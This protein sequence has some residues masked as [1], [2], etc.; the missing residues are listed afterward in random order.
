MLKS[1]ETC[2]YDEFTPEQFRIMRSMMIDLVLATD[3]ASHFKD[4]EHYKDRLHS[5][6]FDCRRGS[7][8]KITMNLLIHIADISNPTKPWKIC[9]RWID[10]LFVE[11]FNQG[12]IERQLGLPVSYLMDRSTT[13][14][15]RAQGGFIDNL[16]APAF[17]TLVQV[18]PKA[19]VCIDQMIANKAQWKQLEGEYDKI[20]VAI[21]N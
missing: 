5:P 9:L 8:K 19:Q 6:D 20:L 1:E 7:D 10:L 4:M 11:F 16:I 21:N 12:D 14:I 2:I 13:N 3:M 15:A 18:I 17:L